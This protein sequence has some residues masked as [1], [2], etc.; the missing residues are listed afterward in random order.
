[1]LLTFVP[2]ERSYLRTSKLLL[3]Q[4]HWCHS[5]NAISRFV[6][7]SQVGRVE[8][9]AGRVSQ[10]FFVI[11]SF[12]WRIT[13]SLAST[14]NPPWTFWYLLTRYRS[15][16]IIKLHTSFPS[17]NSLCLPDGAKYSNDHRH[18]AQH[19]SLLK[20]SGPYLLSSTDWFNLWYRPIFG[21]RRVTSV[22]LL[23][24]LSCLSSVDLVVHIFWSTYLEGGEMLASTL[25]GFGIEII[26]NID[27]WN[28]SSIQ[29][30]SPLCWLPF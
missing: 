25:L 14:Y 18:L 8:T 23:T 1:M 30:C 3:V 28:W 6:S 16:F 22:R 7:M 13:E 4:A 15:P 5:Y 27:E 20:H 24:A 9:T 12:L 19:E 2:R 11:A 21:R 29:K 17:A 26:F 10:F